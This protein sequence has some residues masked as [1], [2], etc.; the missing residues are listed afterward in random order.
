MNIYSL[1]EQLFAF[2]L[3]CRSGS[4]KNALLPLIDPCE[5]YGV[6]EQPWG[7][8]ARIQPGLGAVHYGE[9]GA[10]ATALL[11]RCT[12]LLTPLAEPE[13]L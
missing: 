6:V 7:T 11:A 4:V 12:R 1:Y 9:S 10:A 3:T 8:A 13:K 2:S 5:P